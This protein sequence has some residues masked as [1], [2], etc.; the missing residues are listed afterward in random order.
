MPTNSNAL[1]PWGSSNFGPF[2]NA[3]TQP[4]ANGTVAPSPTTLTALST[5]GPTLFL[6][7][8]NFTPSVLN[9][10]V[11]DRN[12]ETVRRI[13]SNISPIFT[14]IK[15]PE[16]HNLALI[17]WNSL[18]TVEITGVIPKQ[19]ARDWLA[20]TPEGMSRIMTVGQAYYVW[21]PAGK[22]VCLYSTVSSTLKILARI[23]KTPMN[24]ALEMSQAAIDLS[25]LEPCVVATVLL[26]SGR[27]ID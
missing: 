22:Y 8:T 1:T 26:Q 3:S 19:K 13:C 23:C 12:Y 7:F 9:C 27:N 5:S 20:L 4:S 16:G 25:L 6:T 14:L 2:T 17:E 18:P 24:V 15:D 21:A 10:I 11:I